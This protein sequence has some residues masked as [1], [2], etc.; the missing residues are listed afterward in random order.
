MKV[1]FIV[2]I[3]SLILTSVVLAKIG[4]DQLLNGV[5]MILMVLIWILAELM[6]LNNKNYDRER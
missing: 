5:S 4:I 6:Q 2:Y 3:I 1:K